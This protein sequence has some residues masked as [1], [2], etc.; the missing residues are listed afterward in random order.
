M[1]RN[2]LLLFLVC[3]LSV[4][5][6]AVSVCAQGQGSIHLIGIEQPAQIYLVANRDGILL[7]PYDTT[8]VE[9]ILSEK[10]AADKANA[11]WACAVEKG[12]PLT[13]QIPGREHTAS[14]DA[15]DE[16]VYLIGS[17]SGEFVPFVVPIPMELDGEVLWN[18]Q[19]TPKPDDEPDP[20]EP[21]D[22]SDDPPSDPDIPQTGTS[23]I[24]MYLLMIVGTALTV[25]G[26]FELLRGRKESHE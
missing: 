11:L 13:E 1:K 2:K 24:P 5:G 22:P 7:P 10:G 17:P 3:L 12:T 14:F 18:I 19:S 9:D 15:L 16:G 26:L 20:S 21:T 23:V 6:F 25:V 4:F 8:S